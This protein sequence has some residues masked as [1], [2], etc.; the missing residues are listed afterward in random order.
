[1]VACAQLDAHATWEQGVNEISHR[2]IRP[3]GFS[4]L[5]VSRA[6]YLCQGDTGSAFYALDDAL[7]VLSRG[8]DLS[9]V[10]VDESG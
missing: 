1:M 8:A 10:E 3:A 9:V 4:I 2:V 7:F 6:P 5:R